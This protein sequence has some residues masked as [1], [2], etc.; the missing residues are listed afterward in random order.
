MEEKGK[1]T[2]VDLEKQTE[3]LVKNAFSSDFS[4]NF[5]SINEFEKQ[6]QVLLRETPIEKQENRPSPVKHLEARQIWG[7]SLEENKKPE[8]LI[9]E[10]KV[11][12]K[13]SITTQNVLFTP[14]Y[15]SIKVNDTGI[16]FNVKEKKKKKFRLK[17]I[18]VAYAIIL[19]LCC[20]WVTYNAVELTKTNYQIVQYLIKIDQLDTASQAQNG[21][22]TVVTSI[23]EVETR[24]LSEPTK[25]QPQTN[26][27]DRLCSFF[28][29]I[30][31]G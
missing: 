30:F 24:E 5:D 16:K 3:K 20:G 26:W 13:E 18:T 8:V 12:Q 31:G 6:R 28:S 15:D 27:F 17:L 2:Y 19:A 11:T 1:S 23:V 7:G 22:G 10:K 21:D 9:D 29:N 4:K 25:T 14:N